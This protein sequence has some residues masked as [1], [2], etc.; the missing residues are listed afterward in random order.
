[1]KKSGFSRRDFLGVAAAAGLGAGA[2][3]PGSAEPH[4][5][6]APRLPFKVALRSG[7][8]PDRMQ[9]LKGI[10][11]QIEIVVAEGGAQWQSLR[12]DSEVWFG[13]YTPDDL[14]A[15]K[16][17][18][19]I[20]Y[21]AAG[22]EK[23]LYPEL[24]NSPILLTNA[25]GCYA[26]EISEHVFGLL[27][28]LTRGIA[29]QIRNMREHRW[30]ATPTRPMEL[31]KLTMGIIGFGGI[32]RETARRAKAMDMRVVAADIE[33]LYSVHYPMA[34]ELH[35]VETGLTDVLKQSD[36]VVMAAPHTKKSEGMIGA[37][38]FAAMKDGAYFI[39]VC[40]GK[41]VQTPALVDALKSRKIAG[42]GLDVTD[43][44]PL[45]PD[46]ALW[47]MPNVIITSHIAGQS[48]FAYERVQDVFVENVRRFAAG[49]PLLNVVNKEAGY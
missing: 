16:K 3:I 26:P 20:Q 34:D 8:S 31:H 48:Q 36:V 30:A 45:P 28:G 23:I 24:V 17:L 49:L 43:P 14:R 33:P 12:A 5:A 6:E 7:L 41:L 39:N 1:M 32:G 22:V 47:D 25:K 29:N 21:G 13:G 4:E 35:L 46:H 2:A 15:A 37:K 38:E 44:E 9:V 42:A 27:F 10:S 18:K 11:P 19:W 40:R